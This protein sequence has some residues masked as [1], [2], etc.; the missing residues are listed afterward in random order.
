MPHGI[1]YPAKLLL[2][3]RSPRCLRES[4]GPR[5]EAWVQGAGPWSQRSAPPS[6]S[7][8]GWREVRREEGNA[9]QCMGPFLFLSLAH[10]DRDLGMQFGNRRLPIQD[11]LTPA[12]IEGD[13]QAFAHLLNT[14]L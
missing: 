10:A 14:S 6:P 12:V 8:E 2:A 3:T 4:E 9:S 11:L 5:S 7:A 13:Q 1:S